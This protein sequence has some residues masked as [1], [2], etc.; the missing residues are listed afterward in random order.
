MPIEAQLP[1]AV[2]TKL[3]AGDIQE[4]QATLA[5]ASKTKRFPTCG[6]WSSVDD[7]I[8]VGEGVDGPV[9][10]GDAGVD[11]GTGP[12]LPDDAE[13][14][15]DFA[16]AG[17]VIEIGVEVQLQLTVVF[18][19][20]EEQDVTGQAAWSVEDETVADVVRGNVTG[21]RAGTTRIAAELGGV[22]AHFE[23]DV[24]RGVP[25]SIEVQSPADAVP[26]GLT[27]QL[28]AT[29]TYQGGYTEENATDILTWASSDEAVATISDTGE[30]TGVT[31]GN[32]VITAELNGVTSAAFELEVGPA[33]LQSIALGTQQIGANE[34]Q[35]TATGTYSDA[36][37]RDITEEV[38][39]EQVDGEA[40]GTVDET[41]RLTVIS[42]GPV[43]VRATLDGVSKR[44][45]INV[46][47]G[48]GESDAG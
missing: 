25:E 1:K 30:V 31:E 46:T 19:D 10:G 40:Y 35:V 4:V 22:V 2:C 43:T 26:A 47:N 48:G 7:G 29:I 16:N 3:A 15:I 38:T 39:W 12:S 36:S 11:S 34:Y 24:E 27:L 17:D 9:S 14:I 32:A 28:A 23:I 41:G 21:K 8:D 45:T 13:L 5:C 44:V 6:P 37:Q 18:S 42:L 20:G 33:I